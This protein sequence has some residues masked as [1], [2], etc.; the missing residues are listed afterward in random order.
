[1]PATYLLTRHS[2]QTR[3]VVVGAPSFITQALPNVFVVTVSRMRLH[4]DGHDA[5]LIGYT[6]LARFAGMLKP[7]WSPLVG[8]LALTAVDMD[9]ESWR[10]RVRHLAFGY[11]A[12][13]SFCGRPSALQALAPRRRTHRGRRIYA[14]TFAARSDRFTGIRRWLFARLD[15][16][17]KVCW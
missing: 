9:R 14:G 15:R 12:S 4:A 7:L 5:V 3:P 10:T 17:Q 11:G 6:R 16:R 8:S 13:T 1:V 2:L